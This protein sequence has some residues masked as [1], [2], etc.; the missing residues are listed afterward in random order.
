MVY[1]K[2]ILKF[3]LIHHLD[4]AEQ[5]AA[6]LIEFY[7]KNDKLDDLISVVEEKKKACSR[8]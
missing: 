8:L 7:C 1:P 6:Q 5:E 4:Y 3:E 2:D